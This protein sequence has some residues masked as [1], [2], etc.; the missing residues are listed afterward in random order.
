MSGR[1]E[2]QKRRA[3][4]PFKSEAPKD[5]AEVMIPKGLTRVQIPKDIQAERPASGGRS[6]VHGARNPG[7]GPVVDPA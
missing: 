6:R 1:L 2:G 3:P 7:N 5:Q 4:L